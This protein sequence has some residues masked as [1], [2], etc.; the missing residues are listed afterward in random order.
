MSL[1]VVMTPAS[2]S[3]EEMHEYLLARIAA[4]ETIVMLLW[5]ESQNRSSV[6]DGAKTIFEAE[7]ANALASTSTDSSLSVRSQANKAVFERVF[8]ELLS[9]SEQADLRK[10]QERGG[11]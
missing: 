2:P 5:N 1:G 8:S 9:A 7:A 11:E 3:L 4:L 10:L 6:R